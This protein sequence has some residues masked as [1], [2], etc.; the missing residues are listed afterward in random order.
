MQVAPWQELDDDEMDRLTRQAADED[1]VV[2]DDENDC[3][4]GPER[5]G[6]AA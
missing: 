3:P 1:V 6:E 2:W 4:D 5:E